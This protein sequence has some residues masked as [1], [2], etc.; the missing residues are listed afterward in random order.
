MLDLCASVNGGSLIEQSAAAGKSD[1]YM[2]GE[3]FR[4]EHV[5]ILTAL[6]VSIFYATTTTV[7]TC[8]QIP[9][10]EKDFP[11]SLAV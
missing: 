8:V 7:H 6:V 3:M 11:R 10:G 1:D 9:T 2:G 5:H 4:Y